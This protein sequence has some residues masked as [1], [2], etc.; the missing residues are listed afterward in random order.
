MNTAFSQYQQQNILNLTQAEQLILLYDEAIKQLNLAKFY[1]GNQDFCRCNEAFHRAHKIN[2]Y[3]ISI[4]NDH[5]EI[6][7]SL[8]Q[9]Y[10][11]CRRQIT[12]ANTAKNIKLIEDVLA[13]YTELREAFQRAQEGLR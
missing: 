4:L 5:Y 7:E 2:N 6:S 13:V 9:L 8:L 3:L 10:L 12:E 11:F 1:I